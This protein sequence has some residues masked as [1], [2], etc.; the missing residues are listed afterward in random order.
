MRSHEPT[1]DHDRRKAPLPTDSELGVAIANVVETFGPVRAICQGCG[2][3]MPATASP[4]C[5][6]CHFGLDRADSPSHWMPD[7]I[8]LVERYGPAGKRG[9]R[10]ATIRRLARARMRRR[11]KK[12]AP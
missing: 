3:K 9:L 11:A 2:E 12:L 1:R 4:F 5:F 8:A 10:T 7:A 6:A